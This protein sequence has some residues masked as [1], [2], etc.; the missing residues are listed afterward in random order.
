[1]RR[2]NFFALTHTSGHAGRTFSHTRRNNMATLKPPT[3]LL[4]PQ[5]GTAE[6]GIT[7]APDNCTKNAHFAPAKAMTVSVEAQPAP[8]KATTVSTPHRY[9]QAKATPVSGERAPAHEHT[10]HHRC[11]GRRRDLP[12]CRWAVA[13]PGRASRRR[14]EPHTSTP[15]ATGVKGAGGTGGHGRA[16]RRGAERS[17]DA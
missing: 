7:S 16:S 8:T 3:P 11:G 17:E 12:R 13:G 4:A 14:A 6:T 1:M 2:A 9:Q 10:R 5:Q 15:G